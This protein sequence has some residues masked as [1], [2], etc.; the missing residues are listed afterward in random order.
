[1]RVQGINKILQK[2]TL[3]VLFAA[4][5]NLSFHVAMP[6]N[7][8]EIHESDSF[9]NAQIFQFLPFGEKETNQTSQNVISVQ[10]LPFSFSNQWS[11]LQLQK[12]TIELFNR[13]GVQVFKEYPFIVLMKNL[14]I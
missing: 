13:K 7:F 12:Y 9:L 2:I 4:A 6:Q 10:S 8:E 1:M 5:L 3:I 11:P 14:R